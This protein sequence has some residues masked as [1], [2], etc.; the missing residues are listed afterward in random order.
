MTWTI[1]HTHP[2]PTLHEAFDGAAKAALR[3]QGERPSGRAVAAII[4]EHPTYY[5][6]ILRGQNAP[7][8]KKVMGW[9]EAFNATDRATIELEV[10]GEGVVARLVL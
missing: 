1:T 3:H 4:G 7:T 9:L 10:G 8:T 6:A 2:Y 5:A